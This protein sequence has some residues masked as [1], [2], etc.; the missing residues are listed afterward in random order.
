MSDNPLQRFWVAARA[1]VPRL[2]EERPEAW[3]FGASSDPAQA[4][5]LLTLVLDGVK[6]ATSSSA[7]DYEAAQEPLPEP[8]DFSIICDSTGRPRAVIETTAV[9]VTPFNEVDAAHAAAEGEGD[10]TLAY[11][12]REHERFWRAHSE[13]DRGFAADMP[14][15]CERFVVVFALRP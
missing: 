5:R 9:E 10:R 7:W 15:V 1:A 6:T 11:W 2:P 13:N 14:V 8:G 3:A 12:R 4:D